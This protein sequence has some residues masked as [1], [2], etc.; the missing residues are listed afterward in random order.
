MAFSDAFLE[1]LRGRV[2]VS[3]VAT[4]AGL[5]L[6]R[7]GA[8]FKALSPFNDEKTPSFTIND[9]KGFFHC[10]SS[11]KHGDVFKFLMETKGLSFVDSVKEIA[12]IAGIAVPNGEFKPNGTHAPK[13]DAAPVE[14]KERVQPVFVTSYQYLTIEGDT[15]YEVCRF[16][17]KT[18]RQRRPAPGHPG[19]WVWGL[20]AGEF[21]K[22]DRYPDF[23]AASADRI[24]AKGW[25]IRLKM[26]E[27]VTHGL[28]N[29]PEIMEEMRQDEEDRRM[30]F[31]CYSPD[32]EVLTRTGWVRFDALSHDED[33]AQWR[34]GYV[35]FVRPSRHQRYRYSGEM[36][37]IKS[38][39]VDL[40]VTPD[41]RQPI[42]RR[43]KGG[44]YTRHVFP[45]SK[46]RIGQFLPTGGLYDN[47]TEIHGPTPAQA[48]MIAA[49]Q[50][51][52]IWEKRGNKLCFRLKKARKCERLRELLTLIGADW[53]ECTYPSTPGYVAFVM[54][55]SA[56]SMTNGGWSWLPAQDKSW[57]WEYLNWSAD[58]RR[59]MLLESAHW[60]GDRTTE[61]CIRLFTSKRQ[62]VDV[63][64]AMAALTG[65]SCCVRMDARR[66]TVNYIANM[67]FARGR[68]ITKRPLRISYDGD[69]FCCTVQSG[70]LL[71]RR[72][73]KISVS[74]N[75]EGEK[76]CLTLG[77]MNLL[78][79]TNSGGAKHWQPH[80]AEYLRGAD[81]VITLD[82]D[83]PGRERGEAIARTLQGV[84][85]RIRVL[86]WK[87]YWPEV[88][89]KGDVT[90]W[91]SQVENPREKLCE[92]IEKL[93]PWSPAPYKSDFGAV[94]WKELGVRRQAYEYLIQGVLPA[95]ERAMIYGEPEGGK[96]F[97][98]TD[99]SLSIARGI[100][101]EGRRVKQA[102]VIYAAWEGGKGFPNRVEGYRQWHGLEVD[103]NIPFVM[104]TRNADLFGDEEVMKKIQVEIDHW[105]KVFMDGG[106]PLG[107][108]VFDTVSASSGAMDE[109]HGSDVAK[110]LAKGRIIAESFNCTILYV[111]HV[112][113]GGSTPRGSSKFTGDLE[114]TLTVRPDA[115][116]A[117]DENGRPIK[118]L[119]LGKQREG[120]GNKDIK[121][122]VIRQVEI[123]RDEFDEPITTCVV[124]P[125]GGD[126]KAPERRGFHP[127]P[128][129]SKVFRALLDALEKNGA[130][131]DTSM[132][133][134]TTIER[135][136]TYAQWRD[137]YAEI[138][139]GGDEEEST[140][141]A[142]IKTAMKRGGE[143][144]MKFK[145]IGKKEFD[146]RN[147]IF[148]HTGE[149][150]RGFPE[151]FK[152][153][154]TYRRP[155][156]PEPVAMSAPGDDEF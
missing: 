139:I 70:F 114:T 36:I 68:T 100:P 55:K 154:D 48:R 56:L 15:A 119:R 153:Q 78:A 47:S 79:T 58:A 128:Q 9:Q 149:P 96:S 33:I 57:Q 91:Y 132:E 24:P 12:S 124:L 90:D 30:V 49:W 61:I 116:G 42:M 32:T 134:P 20:D 29:F 81:V 17:P 60:D 25:N 77:S 5:K 63:A 85:R 82:N 45:A 126:A 151:T 141:A 106:T 148:W 102:G 26:D 111:H 101:Y 125:P 145:I 117:C 92:I 95:H 6:T 10:F 44:D 143:S 64:S 54:R 2:P 80:L 88:P 150:V 7:A 120:Q 112:P 39:Y 74:G 133:V 89:E 147:K 71:V 43:D 155:P 8:E 13:L 16:E 14:K 93:S 65:G 152:K 94:T 52:G 103:E 87:I 137:A 129:E 140:R 99:M 107:L 72:N 123:G 104:L 51:D 118:V 121:R 27:A 66:G 35:E 21:V 28:F 144:L 46:V 67:Y 86:D 109:N 108:I 11:S 135:V 23:Y 37:S 34:D 142:R 122:F 59:A 84:A 1:D 22:H 76:D 31:L 3:E 97:A 53:E 113:K 83:K 62:T 127:T 115:H 41:H 146:A 75:C 50:A 136:V 98:A 105:A 73:G 38:L 138:D 156:D 18:F 19:A 130:A 131:P 110:Y 69:V 40:L 4:R